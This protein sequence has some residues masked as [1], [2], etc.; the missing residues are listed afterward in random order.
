M[1]DVFAGGLGIFPSDPLEAVTLSAKLSK[2]SY[3]HFPSWTTCGD[4]GRGFGPAFLFFCPI[5]SPRASCLGIV[6]FWL[7]APPPSPV[8]HPRCLPDAGCRWNER[9][10]CCWRGFSNQWLECL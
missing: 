10:P 7:R 4:T 2:Q 8:P 5:T 1:A 9:S 6:M 3:V